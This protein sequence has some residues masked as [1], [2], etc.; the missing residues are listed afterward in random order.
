V[1]AVDVEVARDNRF[2]VNL[3]ITDSKNKY[4]DIVYYNLLGVDK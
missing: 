1:L 2:F 3:R 4:A